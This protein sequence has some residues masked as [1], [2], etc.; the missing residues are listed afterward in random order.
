MKPSTKQ[1]CRA[2]LLLCGLFSFNNF[3]SDINPNKLESAAKHIASM[4]S[5][6]KQ[7]ARQAISQLSAEQ[8]VQIKKTLK[9]K[10]NELSDEEKARLKSQLSG[11]AVSH[12]KLLK[13]RVDKLSEAD[14]QRIVQQIVQQ[15]EKSCARCQR[16]NVRNSTPNLKKSPRHSNA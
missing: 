9:E 1:I 7:A 5:E 10:Y 11:F 14:K 15:V 2:F 8:K 4:S 12:P 6:Q 3:A 16:L 13:A